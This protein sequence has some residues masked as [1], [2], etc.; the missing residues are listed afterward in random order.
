MQVRC[1]RRPHSLVRLIN[2]SWSGRRKKAHPERSPTA[3]WLKINWAEPQGSRRMNRHANNRR[4]D[5]AQLTSL[6]AAGPAFRPSPTPAA[7]E[8]HYL[9]SRVT[10]G[11]GITANRQSSKSN[12]DTRTAHANPS[13]HIDCLMSSTPSFARDRDSSCQIRQCADFACG[14]TRRYVAGQRGFPVFRVSWLTCLNEVD[15]MH[16]CVCLS[17]REEASYSRPTASVPAPAVASQRMP[18]RQMISLTRRHRG[19]PH[20]TSTL[21]GGTRGRESIWVNRILGGRGPGVESGRSI[22]ILGHV[23]AV[24]VLWTAF[25]EPVRI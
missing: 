20:A 3:N 23:G 16:S 14:C 7:F 1:L 11:F 4:L 5:R 10:A 24:Q 19:P 25:L 15:G 9:L 2:R 13:S 6:K 18:K 8:I 12:R 21:Q 17:S 22:D